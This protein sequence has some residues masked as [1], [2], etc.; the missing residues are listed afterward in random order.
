MAKFQVK[1]DGQW[2]DYNDEQDKIL[3]HALQ[4]GLGKVRFRVRGQEYECDFGRMVQIHIASGWIDEVR[5]PRSPRASSAP[6]LEVKKAACHTGADQKG[7]DQTKFQVKIDGEW[8]NY[9]DEEDAALKNALK[10]GLPKTRLKL[11][12]CEYEYDFE[13]KWQLNMSSGKFCELW[14]PRC[15]AAT[16][17]K[18]ASA[19]PAGTKA[20][21]SKKDHSAQDNKFQVKIDGAWRDYSSQED[22]ILKRAF[23][24]GLP[25]AAFKVRGNEYLYDFKKM[26]QINKSTGK[27]FEIRAPYKW[28]LPST[29]LVKAGPTTCIKIPQGGPGTTILVPHPTRKGEHFAVVVPS[30]AKVGQV[31]LVPVPGLSPRGASTPPPPCAPSSPTRDLSE[32]SKGAGLGKKLACG[33]AIVGGAAVTGAVIG[34]SVSEDGFD[35]TMEELGE[36]LE[37]AV[38]DAGDWFED[39]GDDI[40]DFIVDLF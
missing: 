25:H 14:I 11:R 35:S 21:V 32:K 31:M 22:G 33:M 2:K 30:H 28:K 6:T 34:G 15:T 16:T 29:P 19:V 8:K 36:G 9:S 20:E 10:A 12:G 40:G 4:S 18:R 5:P 13:N 27:S 24:A 17:S 23:K 1:L 7:L 26:T 37:D 38:D 39:T 3:K